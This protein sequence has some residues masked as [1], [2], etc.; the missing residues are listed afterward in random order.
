[1][2]DHLST[3]VKLAPIVER[4]HGA[5]HPELTRVRELTQEIS[6]SADAM[7]AAD[8]FRRLRKVTNDYAVPSDGCEAF[9]ATYQ[10]L[11]FADREQSGV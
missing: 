10:A 8:L 7:A 11:R 9:A 6:Q 5:N 3:A 2:T 1:V 4:V